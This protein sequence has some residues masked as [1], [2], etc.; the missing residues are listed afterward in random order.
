ME[1]RCFTRWSPRRCR[2][3]RPR[4]TLT[5]SARALGRFLPTWSARIGQLAVAAVDQHGEAYGAGPAEV[6]ERVER[7]ADRAAGEEHVVDE[8][9][10]LAV[11]P[12]GRQRGLVRAPGRLRAQVVAVHRH[13]ELADRDGRALDGGDLLGDAP[14]QRHAAG[15]QAEQHQVGGAL[16]ALEQLVR[17]AGQRPGDV[18]GVEDGA[19]RPLARGVGSRS[20][21]GAGICAPDLLLRLTG[22]LVK[23]CRSAAT[24][25]AGRVRGRD[26]STLR[27]DAGLSAHAGQ[28]LHMGDRLRQRIIAPGIIPWEK[29]SRPGPAAPSST[30]SIAR[31]PCRPDRVRRAIDLGCGRGFDTKLLLD[32]G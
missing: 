8:D 29:A 16:V 12:A 4:R 1:S 11:D 25:P 27:G 13:V 9:D 6:G 19:V 31:R 21:S 3:S 18:T 14:R 2:R 17:D 23:G 7:G 15:V 28:E 30:S 20:S 5:R 26:R 24:L 10:D 22:R 32:R